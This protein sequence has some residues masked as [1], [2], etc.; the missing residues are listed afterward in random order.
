M[1]E[2]HHLLAIAERRG[3]AI[4]VDLL[5]SLQSYCHDV[6]AISVDHDVIR[7]KAF[8]QQLTAVTRGMR[9]L[10]P[11]ALM[12]VS[13]ALVVFWRRGNQPLLLGGAAIIGI[14]AIV[15]R[16]WLMTP[17]T[18]LNAFA[19]SHLLVA[20]SLGIGW[21]TLGWGIT[22]IGDANVVMMILWIQMGVIASGLVMYYY[23]PVAFLGFSVPIAIPMTIM[24]AGY[25]I[26]G[27]TSASALTILY[28]TVLGRA[29]VDQ[30]RV[31]VA[32]S[33]ATER[34]IDSEAATR[35][36]DSLTAAAR[37]DAANARTEAAHL[38]SEH[39]AAAATAAGAAEAQRRNVM[40]E[41]AEHFEANVLSV[42]QQVSAAVFD[43]EQSAQRLAV[44]ADESAGA[45]SEVSYRAKAAS[46][47][48]S[49]LAAAANQLGTTITHI[50]SQVDDHATLSAGAHALAEASSGAIAGM[51]DR[52]TQIGNMT[53]VITDVAK[54]TSLLALNATIEAARAGEAGRGFA[55]VAAEVKSLSVHTRVTAGDVSSHIEN[56]FAQVDVAT[57]AVH[58][59][60]SSIDGVA[61]I[62][63]SIAG[64][65]DDQR[66]ATV[67]IGKAVEVVANHVR[68]MRDQVTSFAESADAT[69]RLTEEVGAT[70]R[71]VSMQ[72]TMLQQVTVAFLDE[73]RLA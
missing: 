53:A 44:I 62:A 8:C 28:L 6:V 67:E 37:V 5:R 12:L 58:K 50:A 60:V 1:G 26:G 24:S 42:A 46:S 48:V 43:L 66:N 56:I 70:S 45:V 38:R 36:A 69:G 68:D 61:A 33:C 20:I 31:F 71:R 29:A 39:I 18:D 19:R 32:A 59:T 16:V 13:I 9:P 3:H 7:Q 30:C 17:G 34:L 51:C 27:L 57:D 65:I 64:S 72:S 73:L 54:Q 10:I 22:A 11:L 2:N 15:A 21:G 47:S 55:V 14:T 40:I 35:A 63:T 52:A 4:G 25:G 23:L 49:T 41:L